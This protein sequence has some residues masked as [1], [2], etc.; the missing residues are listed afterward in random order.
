MSRAAQE[1]KWAMGV[2]SSEGQEGLQRLIMTVPLGRH[3][4]GLSSVS[5]LVPFSRV[6]SQRNSAAAIELEVI[7][8]EGGGI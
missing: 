6:R 8:L 4:G 3:F 2:Q 7:E 5:T 1:N